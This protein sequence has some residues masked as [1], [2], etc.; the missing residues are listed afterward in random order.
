MK[1]QFS[2]YQISLNRT[3]KIFRNTNLRRL[4]EIA[5]SWIIGYWCGVECYVNL[6][7]DS[8]MVIPHFRVKINY[9]NLRNMSTINFEKKPLV[10]IIR[11]F[12]R[13]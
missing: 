6:P 12:L 3:I 7:H 10:S 2:H 1:T 5:N 9:K 8:F 4:G 11:L 13:K